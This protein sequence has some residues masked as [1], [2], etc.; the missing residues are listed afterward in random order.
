MKRDAEEDIAQS[1][2]DAKEEIRKE[3]VSLALDASSEILSRNVNTK[4]NEKLADDFIR[5]MGK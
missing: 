4:D 5:S 2:E 1:K 3:M